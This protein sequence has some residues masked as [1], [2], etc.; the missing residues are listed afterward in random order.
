MRI[1]RGIAAFGIAAMCFA[2][3]P[4][5]ALA[6]DIGSSVI[7]E[8]STN[9]LNNM[10][11]M[12]G[13]QYQVYTNQDCAANHKATDVNGNN[14]M[15][16]VTYNNSTKKAVTNTVELEPGTYWVK[17]VPE[18][19]AGK[20][21]TV[22]TT[23]YRADV[24]SNHTEDSPL[25]LTSTEDVVRTDEGT[26]KK[27]D[28]QFG[29]TPAGD[30]T[31]RGCVI[32]VRYFDE[33]NNSRDA[34]WYNSH[35]SQAKA[36]W[37]F[38]TDASGNIS[39]KTSPLASGYTSSA[40]KTANGQRVY[41]L[42]T[43]V[44]DE[45]KAPEGYNLA[46]NLALVRLRQA[47]VT[48]TTPD[49]VIDFSATDEATPQRIL[50]E[51]RD[52]EIPNGQTT[53]G[54]T[55]ANAQVRYLEGG[56]TPANTLTQGDTDH[57][58][59]YI[60]QNVSDHPISYV[61]RAGERVTVAVN[62]Y[63]PDEF[64]CAV[65]P[66]GKWVTPS[67]NVTY[68]TYKIT[69]KSAGQG[70]KLDTTW[71]QTVEAHRDEAHSSTP[72]EYVQLNVPVRAGMGIVK[73]DSGTTDPNHYISNGHSL[74]TIVADVMQGQGDARLD[75]AEFTVKNVSRNAVLVNGKWY[76]K[77]AD[78]CVLTTY[79]DEDGHVVAY[80]KTNVDLPYG[81]YEVRETKA[82][83][84][85]HKRDDLIGGGPIILHPKQ[86]AEGTWYFAGWAF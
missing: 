83:E 70:M 41:L 80:T 73:I 67:I 5:P 15:L 45:V 3:A 52:G 58:S 30:G 81:T 77:G 49:A 44:M 76:A 28:S 4:A 75:G 8:S 27:L 19:V 55:V 10:Y 31:L 24:T 20:G 12:D 11:E 57:S 38:A 40:I 23:V 72:Y 25:T 82:P 71:Y 59:T 21:L 33:V 9:D 60:V 51:K 53:T 6:V 16:T 84:G 74:A 43:Y 79:V 69:E 37:Y 46:S 2:A 18:S 13:V 26:I 50:I 29:T 64:T 78:I 7:H 66:N 63:L 1:S 22:D 56:A 62:D 14:A 47:S 65:D 54:E 17:E 32:R 48:S 42:G 86:T 34:A 61:N 36:T 68:G 39:M 35:A 85:Y